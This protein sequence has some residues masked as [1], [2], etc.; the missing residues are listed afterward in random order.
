M[1]SWWITQ[2]SLLTIHFSYM[3]AELTRLFFEHFAQR[4][5]MACS[6]T[7]ATWL[8]SCFLN[9]RIWKMNFQWVFC[10]NIPKK[11]KISWSGKVTWPRTKKRRKS[12]DIKTNHDSEQQWSVN[13]QKLTASKS[14]FKFLCQEVISFVSYQRAVSFTN[15]LQ[16]C[17]FFG[18][19]KF[20]QL[21]GFW[22]MSRQ[23]WTIFAIQK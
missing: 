14:F 12:P 21:C 20:Y 9:E 23:V 19:T 15:G 11:E 8:L 1:A 7:A 4:L 13:K 18:Q 2:Y 16:D 6:I 17:C 22:K 3:F 5:E 10:T